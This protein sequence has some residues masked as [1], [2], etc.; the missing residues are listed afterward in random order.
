MTSPS[1]EESL[2]NRIAGEIILSNNPGAT[3]RKW[4]ELLDISQTK[5]AARLSLS[6]SVISDYESGRRKSPGTSFVRKFVRALISMDMSAGGKFV[7]EMS[8]LTRTASDA[9][10]DIKEFSLPV[11]AE[12]ICEIVKGKVLSG[13]EL[14]ERD[15]YGYTVVDSIKAI[16]SLSGNDFLQIF[17][18]TSERAIVFTG[19]THGRSPLIA[20]KVH[21]LKPKMI[22]IH[23]Q[24]N[25][26]DELAVKLAEYDQLLLVLSRVPSVEDLV[27]AL[28]RLYR[29]TQKLTPSKAGTINR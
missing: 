9:I 26:V 19:V 11:K 14:L 18:S 20:I 16:T 5:L 24:I 12:K 21:Q 4:R 13:R 7:R 25:R 1:I 29:A 17:G 10:L 8:R 15:V 23:G 28:N 6:P 22:I 3:M 27:R 2:S